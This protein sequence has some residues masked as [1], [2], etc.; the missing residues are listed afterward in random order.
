[1]D[2]LSS[3]DLSAL[4]SRQQADEQLAAK[5]SSA[6]VRQ[7][8]LTNLMRQEDGSS[9]WRANLPVLQA[10]QNDS[11]SY[12]PPL[13]ARYGGETL[14]LGGARSEYRLDQEQHLMLQYFP[15]SHLEMLPNAG[16]WIH[17]EAVEAF[18]ALVR[19][20]VD[21]GLQGFQ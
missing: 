3:L 20:F 9:G 1:L 7:F 15:H 6:T 2:A 16:H 14:F 12:E 8:V 4:T 19:R 13:H 18:T 17:F 5:I 10:Y 21:L 11:A